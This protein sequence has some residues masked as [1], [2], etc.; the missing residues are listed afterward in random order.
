MTWTWFPCLRGSPWKRVI[1]GILSDDIGIDDLR[2]S[3][4]LFVGAD[5]PLGPAYLALGY[6]DAGDLA[7]YFYLGNP[8]RVSRFD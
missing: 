5:S 1:P 2:Y 6:G 3:G 7:V 8:F 4:S